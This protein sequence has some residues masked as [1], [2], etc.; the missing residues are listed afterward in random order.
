MD[1]LDLVI[2]VDPTTLLTQ[3]EFRQQMVNIA[4]TVKQM[5]RYIIV[6][7]MN[8]LHPDGEGP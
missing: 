2:I 8:E 3:Q 6:L 1:V 7:N 4:E 5:Y